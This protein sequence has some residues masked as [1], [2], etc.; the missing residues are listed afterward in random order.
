MR[1][2]LPNGV[3]NIGNYAFCDC[4]GLKKA[5]LPD[6]LSFIGLGAFAGCGNMKS[7]T[8][9]CAMKTVTAY[10]FGNCSSL[11][12]V[13][14]LSPAVAFED[15]LEEIPYEDEVYYEDVFDGCLPSLVIHG[16][17]SSTA[18]EYARRFGYAFE[19]LTAPAFFLPASL[20]ELSED[21]FAGVKS[22]VV[23]IPKTVTS[24]SGDP[25]A[26]SGLLYVYGYEDSAA[27]A[28]AAE[29]GYSFLTIDDAWMAANR[30]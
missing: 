21:T 12:D 14:V 19:P 28:F 29:Y 20:I 6:S 22:K 23:I 25:F 18:E 8:L 24:I 3:E 13:T 2:E 11:T 17:L 4:S 9:P 10:A 16:W 30:P 26:G 7:V 15:Y 5:V 27:Q 1:I